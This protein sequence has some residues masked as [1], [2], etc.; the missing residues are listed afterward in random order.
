MKTAHELLADETLARRH[1]DQEE[2]K[3]ETLVRR[4]RTA[5]RQMPFL[6]QFIM[7]IALLA[8]FAVIGRQTGDFCGVYVV[9]GAFLFIG[10]PI[11]LWNLR[12]R[13]Q[14][15]LA[16]IAQEAPQLYRRLRNEGIA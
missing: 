1:R 12:E 6:A 8:V 13:E 5:T 14:A 3:W 10:L 2:R 11:R 15:L 7:T 9:T 16:M 4:C